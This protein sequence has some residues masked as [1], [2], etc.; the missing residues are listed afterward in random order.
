MI[1]EGTV[2]WDDW[3]NN[4]VKKKITSTVLCIINLDIATLRRHMRI[5]YMDMVHVSEEKNYIKLALQH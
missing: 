1:A 2:V 3:E 4:V 5:I